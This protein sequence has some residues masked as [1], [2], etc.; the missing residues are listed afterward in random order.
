MLDAIE[1]RDTVLFYTAIENVED[2]SHTDLSGD[3]IQQYY[4]E[5]KNYDSSK[6]FTL[7]SPPVKNTLVSFFDIFVGS[8][9][10]SEEV[11]LGFYTT[12]SIGKEQKKILIDGQEISP[13]DTPILEMLS[14]KQELNDT[15]VEMIKSALIEEYRKQYTDKDSNGHLDTLEELDIEKFKSFLKQINWFFGAEDE[16][17]LEETIME[18]IKNSKLHNVRHENKEG[19]ILALLMEDLDKKQNKKSLAQ[20]VIFSSEIEL[21]FK[22]AESEESEEIQD[23]TWKE[24]RKIEAKITDKR[25][26]QEKILAVNPDYPQKRIGHLA[27]VACRSKQEQRAHNKSFLSLKYRAYEAC[28]DHLSKA[29]KSI[30]EKEE[31]DKELEHLKKISIEKIA[32]LKS[33]YKYPISNDTAI[34]GIVMDL[35]D[36]CFISFDEQE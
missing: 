35:F 8:W 5:D 16:I 31:V 22:K 36:S 3:D 18:K 26:L 32:Q 25:T 9:K 13:P 12:A 21:I 30:S 29:E 28:S 34:E 10:S 15:T 20:K 27:R 23:P 6:N 24:L 17:S 2:V 7:F 19:I 1:N 14:L 4:E 33:D 11:T